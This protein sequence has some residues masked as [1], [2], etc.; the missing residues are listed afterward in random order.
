MDNPTKTSIPDNQFPVVNERLLLNS[1]AANVWA[2]EFVKIHGGDEDL[3]LAWFAN[4]IEVG[5]AA[6]SR[7]TTHP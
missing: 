5:R 3:M 2:A 6:G 4:S 1:T 7:N